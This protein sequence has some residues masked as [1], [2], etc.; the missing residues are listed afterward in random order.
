MSY[1]N[2]IT[3]LD[4]KN[5]LNL[6][7]ASNGSGKS[8]ILDVI[9]YC[10]YGK[11]YRNIKVASLVN[12]TNKKNLL[13]SI[14]FE[15][16]KSI[17]KITRG[18][19]PDVLS[20]EKD[21]KTIELMSTK[22]LIQEDI[23]NIIGINN[24]LFKNIV[25]VATTYNKPFLSL[26]NND[27]NILFENLFNMDV[28]R[29]ILKVI[30]ADN[31]IDKQN[32]LLAD[33]NKRNNETNIDSLKLSISNLE[34]SIINFKNLTENKKEVEILELQ[35]KYDHNVEL[36]K[37]FENEKNEVDSKIN[38]EISDQLSNLL[39]KRNTKYNEI[40][41]LETDISS[42]QHDIC[43]LCGADISNS[44]ILNSKS[45]LL[46]LKNEE[47]KNI[48]NKITELRKID[49]DN[50]KYRDKS[51]SLAGIINVGNEKNKMYKYM[52]ENKQKESRVDISELESNLKQEHKK[53]DNLIKNNELNEK[54][55][56][57]NSVKCEINNNILK[58]TSEE[59]IKKFIF[60]K[61]I[62]I[63]NNMV[64]SYLIKLSLPIKIKFNDNLD[65][66]LVS[67]GN[68]KEYNSFSA[69]ERTRIDMSI[70]LGFLNLSSDLAN[71]ST[72]ILFI[73]ELFDSGIDDEGILDLLKSLK[74]LITSR[75]Q[76]CYLV[77][78]KL[79]NENLFDN[80]IKPLKNND[81]SYLSQS[82]L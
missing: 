58:L 13:T 30:K 63:L 8:S 45:L 69:G 3:H 9:S 37:N 22:K 55:V 68:N 41:H 57:E 28:L 18:M 62:N 32:L 64:N 29:R 67:K 44:D 21:G 76:S 7:K 54:I 39:L 19:K 71:W 43:P 16:N 59:G 36:I 35:T 81:F 23:D 66:E 38:D 60:D 12:W 2:T 50:K 70:L 4:F 5:G 82:S 53:L 52:I 31:L 20:I 72:N 77:S 75:N 27:R 6:I 51:S 74:E 10:L 49:N 1:G 47:L 25:A 80:I 78:H 34:N 61:M 56:E 26:S 46:K 11:P 17:Y 33:N 79:N 48:D 73:D 15:K 40:L 65:Y 14:V 24:F 42:L